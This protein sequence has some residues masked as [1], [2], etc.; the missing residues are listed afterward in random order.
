MHSEQELER[1]RREIQEANSPEQKAQL[2]NNLSDRLRELCSYDEA[3]SAAESAYTI[4][5]NH[6]LA[7]E[8]G[9]ALNNLGLVTFLKG[10]LEEA[11]AYLQR[12]LAIF[13]T[14]EYQGMQSSVYTAL[15]N[16]HSMKAEYTKA[17]EYLEQGL[18][19]D[20]QRNTTRAIAH[21]KVCLGNIYVNTSDYATALQYFT[22]AYTGFES[23]ANLMGMSAASG[24]MG[25]VYSLLGEHTKALEEY[26]RTLE[27]SSN[28]GSATTEANTI[29]NIATIYF[30]LQEYDAAIEWYQKALAIFE[31]IQYSSGV[32]STLARLGNAYKAR[33]EHKRAASYYKRA[34]KIFQAIEEK[35]GQLFVIGNIAVNHV[36]QGNLDDA[37]LVF[38]EL[39]QEYAQLNNTRLLAKTY[40]NIAT[41]YAN[42]SY[43]KRNAKRALEN[44][45]KALA[46]SQP[47]GTLEDTM[48]IHASLAQ[49]Y[50][51]QRRWEEYA[52]HIENY[53][54]LYKEVQNQEVRKQ[55]DRFGWERKIL[56]ME[57][58][59]EIER[60]NAEREKVEIQYQF[61][62]KANEVE[63]MIHEL[64][65]K[66]S[67]L[68]EVRK[69]VKKLSKDARG[70]NI[71]V[72]EHLLD[73]L[74]RNIVPL[75]TKAELEKQWQEIHAEFME[76][77]KG[78][79][80]LMSPMEIKICALL[81][82]RLTS[83]NISTILF[84]SRR[85]VEFHR[86]NIRKKMGLSKNDDLHLVLNA[87]A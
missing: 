20:V 55:A 25:N 36:E 34:L 44:F 42:P 70:S 9:M 74:E 64:V 72:A 19:I 84:L 66:N 48:D 49:F 30:Q 6:S 8:E 78:L 37:L 79:Y 13:I 11:Y 47:L 53:H 41:V 46:L 12:A 59:R 80:P 7:K 3:Q 57:K 23:I 29:S 27:I 5:T 43:A 73:R 26:K 86:L 58:Q 69:D 68:H 39:L 85:T 40:A 32:A 71:D 61:Q 76:K 16:I 24:S 82:M 28:A 56:E 51:S 18:A 38:K 67:F 63:T 1:L 15:A 81:K 2:L 14:I 45:S 50:R 33:K 65:R 22:E 62:L 75:E 21:K 4:A 60:L 52:K 17:R 87:L 54:E 31:R 77:L 35:N 83:S 10:N